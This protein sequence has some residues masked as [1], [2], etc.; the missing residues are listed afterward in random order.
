MTALEKQISQLIKE[1][2]ELGKTLKENTEINRTRDK[3]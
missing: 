1:I 3:K 2:H